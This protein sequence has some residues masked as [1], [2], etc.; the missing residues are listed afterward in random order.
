MDGNG[1]ADRASGVPAPARTDSAISSLRDWLRQLFGQKASDATL[2]EVLEE[3]LEEHHEEA[4]RLAPQEKT[5]LRNVLSF[6]DMTV[7][8]IM[9]PRTDISAV[10]YDITPEALKAHIHEYRH[11]RIPVYRETLDQVE[12]FLHIKDL[13]PM[14]AGDEAFSLKKALRPMLF[15][16][17]SMR[18]T[19]LLVKMRRIGSHMAIVVDEYGGT[20]GLVTLEDLF[21]EIVGDIQDEHDE[22]Q[23]R[24]FFRLS[25]HVAEADARIRVEKLEDYLDITLRTGEEGDEYDTL[26]GLIFY[27]LGRVPKVGEKIPHA[28]GLTFEIMDADAR[29]VK[30]VR[31][32]N[33]EP[34]A[35]SVE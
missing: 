34:A 12:G 22:D 21:E 13:F 9:I 23:D 4:E 10:P 31:I 30:K 28:S 2:K 20:D 15:V 24:E 7:S 25:D 27:E 6:G 17:A 1:P 35:L 18:I 3:V 19:D 32:L 14:M 33:A 11:T 8:D 16:P 5:M 29:R 26:G